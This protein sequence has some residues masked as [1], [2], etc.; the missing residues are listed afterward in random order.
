MAGDAASLVEVRD[1]PEASRYEIHVDGELAGQA[2]YR[3]DGGAV[4]FTHTE[5]DQDREG[6]GLGSRLAREA[7]DDVVRRGLRI[8]PWCPFMSAY[9]ERHPQ[10]QQHVRRED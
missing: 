2:A 9:I 8:E 4:I 6:Q 5:I 3:L 10:Y 7:L 1:H